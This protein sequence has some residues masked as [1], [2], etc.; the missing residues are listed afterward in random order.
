MVDLDGKPSRL[1]LGA[2]RQ[3]L[4]GLLDELACKQLNLWLALVWLCAAEVPPA[5]LPLLRARHRRQT[6]GLERLNQE[7]LQP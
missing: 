4:Y 7:S 3:R 6:S 2:I 5:D 1:P